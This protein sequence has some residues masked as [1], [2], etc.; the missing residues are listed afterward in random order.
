MMEDI[1]HENETCQFEPD[2][3]YYSDSPPTRS[4]KTTPFTSK[5]APSPDQVNYNEDDVIS[6][7]SPFSHRSRSLSTIL[8]NSNES[9]TAD[10]PLETN[11]SGQGNEF[12]GTFTPSNSQDAHVDENTK[13]TSKSQFHCALCIQVFPSCT[14]NCHFGKNSNQGGVPAVREYVPTSVPE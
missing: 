4:L 14:H 10:K 12:T 11:V 1:T 3:L 5:D 7:M 13:P 9:L 8:F 2:H 6:T